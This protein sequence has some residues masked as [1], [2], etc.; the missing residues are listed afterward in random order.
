M[1]LRPAGTALQNLLRSAWQSVKPTGWVDGLVDYGPDLAFAARAGATAPPGWGAALA[2]EDLALGLG[3]SM[4]G[5]IGADLIG[6]RL[7]KLD[8]IR[9]AERLGQL[10]FAGSMGLS[11]GPALLGFRPVTDMMIKQQEQDIASQQQMAVEERNKHLE[12]QAI[13]AGLNSLGMAGI[14]GLSGRDPWGV[15]A[16]L[17]SA[18]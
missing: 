7:L 11:M 6:Q 16:G 18:R 5:R 14:A 13:A 9:D 1:S 12:E 15:A 4:A 10:R 8:P 2:G 3:A 17:P